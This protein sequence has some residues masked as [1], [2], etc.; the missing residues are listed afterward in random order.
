MLYLVV[1]LLC[2]V[3]A[4]PAVAGAGI[5]PPEG[6]RFPGNADYKDDWLD[7]R[8]QLP[9]PFVVTADFNGDGV[10]DEA[11]ILIRRNAPGWGL[12]VFLSNRRQ[13]HQIIK[14][15]EVNDD[16]P[17][18]TGIALVK[19]GRYKTACGKG[20]WECKPGE[21]EVLVLKRPSF[22]FFKFES[23]SSIFYWDETAATF[24]RI[25]ISD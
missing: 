15:I 14:L 17:Q 8:K 25:W 23:A 11:W 5:R 13:Q 21:P 16:H 2:L 1:S 9:K 19:P 7:F 10:S 24:N 20:Y 12:F 22:K 4:A 18:S 3:L 6:W